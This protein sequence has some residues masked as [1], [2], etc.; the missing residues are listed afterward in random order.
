MTDSATEPQASLNAQYPIGPLPS[1]SV[2]DRK[3]TTLEQFAQSMTQAV[4]DW[5]ALANG[6]S[7]ADLN[8]TYRPQSWTVFQLI[9]H[10]PEAHMYGLTRLKF[11][12][13]EDDYT[14]Q[15]INQQAMMLLPDKQMPIASALALLEALN[16]SWVALLIHVPMQ[17]FYR[18]I[19]HPEEG[20][21]DLW[22]LAAKHDW[23]LRHHLAQARLALVV[24]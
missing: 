16:T 2:E 10:V 1:L 3:A 24:G 9:Q 14:I 22:Q 4:S 7:A 12:L 18:K 17:Q 6:L 5:Q 11:G 13:T 21:Q 8:R 19:M 15:P 23:H 20:P